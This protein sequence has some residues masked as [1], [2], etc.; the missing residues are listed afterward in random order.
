ME[1]GTGIVHGGQVLVTL[2]GA[3]DICKLGGDEGPGLI[4]SH[5]SFVGNWDAKLEGTGPGEVGALDFPLG[6]EYG[7]REVPDGEVL[8]ITVVSSDRR[9][10]WGE[11]GSDLVSSDISLEVVIDNNLEGEVSGTEYFIIQVPDGEV[12]DTTHGESDRIKL[13]GY[14]LG[15]ALATEIET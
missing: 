10:L 4:L 7:I 14:T 2:L 1:G 11:E 8:G 9:K 12:L 5:V 15:K 13:G 6:T 3:A